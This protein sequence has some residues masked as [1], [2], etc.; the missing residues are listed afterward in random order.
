MH[1]GGGC[2]V[3][4]MGSDEVRERGGGGGRGSA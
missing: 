2:T 1:D 4:R 3:W